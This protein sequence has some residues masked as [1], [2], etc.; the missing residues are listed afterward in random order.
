MEREEIVDVLA[1]EWAAIVALGEALSPADWDAASECPGWT[2]RDLVA[3]MVGTE[4]SLLGEAPPPAPPEADGVVPDH[5]RNPTGAANERW[6]AARRGRPGAEVVDE[7]AE[8]TARRLAELRA[9]PPER[10]EEVG[11]SPVGVVP[12]REFMA[13]RVMDCWVHEQDMRVATGRPRRAEGRPAEVAL[14]RIASAMPFVV[15]KRAGA[16]EGSS[17]RFEV[18]GPGSRR[19]DVLVSGGRAAVV[20]SLAAEPTAT[21]TLST[22]A[23]W[24]LGCGRI[25][26]GQAVER[27]LVSLGGDGALSRAVLDSMAFMI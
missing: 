15:G 14:G 20:P 25:T 27:G 8:V 13:V 21:L 24:R 2:V 10:F 19:L 16:A 6:V 22:D 18:E 5:V 12:Y 11:P 1:E 3:H 17:V 23:F 26:G 4:R 9:D 7:F